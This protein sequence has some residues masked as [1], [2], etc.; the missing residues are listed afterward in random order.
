MRYR[1]IEIDE[2]F[3]NKEKTREIVDLMDN[4]GAHL[5][6]AYLKKHEEIEAHTSHSDT[7][8]YVTNGELELIVTH[9]ETCTCTSCGC[10][11]NDEHEKNSKK[12]KI[13]KDQM[14]FFE[15]N[16]VHSIKALK[17]TTFLLIKI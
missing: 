3:T 10:E 8:I 6:I 4:N 13:K 14:F 1:T 15:K 2:F 16:V 12:Y 7:C 9:D 17:D 11:T 5:K